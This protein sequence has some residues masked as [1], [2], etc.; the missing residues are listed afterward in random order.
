MSSLNVGG[1][2]MYD[3]SIA[4]AD[5]PFARHWDTMFGDVLMILSFSSFHIK[6]GK[7]QGIERRESMIS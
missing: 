2:I 7:G 4:E 1:F 3:D 6:V 5:L